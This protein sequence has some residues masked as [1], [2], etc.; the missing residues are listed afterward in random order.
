MGHLLRIAPASTGHSVSYAP[1]HSFL[2]GFSTYPLEILQLS[3]TLFLNKSHK[4]LTPHRVFSLI[5][6][7]SVCQNLGHL[8]STLF[9]TWSLWIRY[10]TPGFCAEV[11]LR[12]WGII[13]WG[14]VQGDQVMAA[15]LSGL[16]HCS[17]RLD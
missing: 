7:M 13:S 9:P 14:P 15:S 12:W 16:L 10:G 4:P 3:K 8:S 17:R 6:P 1:A 2:N 5:C 11:A